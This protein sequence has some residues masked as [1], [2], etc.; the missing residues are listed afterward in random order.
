MEVS[1]GFTLQ[2]R[3]PSRQR[4]GMHGSPVFAWNGRLHPIKDPLTALKGFSRIRRQWPQSRLYMIF[5]T[6][7]LRRSVDDVIAADPD[8]RDSV[9]LRGCL[10]YAAVEDFLNS[11]DF[12][13]LSSVHEGG[14]TYAVLEGMSCG[15]IPVLTDIPSFRAMTDGGKHGLLFP[16]GDHVALAE[17]VLASDRRGIAAKSRE[18][19][20]Y[21]VR[22]LSYDTIAA[23]YEDAF[24]SAARSVSYKLE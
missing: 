11:A 17:R 7:E 22:S 15:L 19:R 13:L 20:D 23:I 4:T 18:V 6:D 3:D 24:R 16:V 12:L 9:E 8:L 2:P 10:P 21:F 5:L 14:S 1:S